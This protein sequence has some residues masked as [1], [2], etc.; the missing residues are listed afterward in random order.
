MP[1][2]YASV[3]SSHAE[4]EKHKRR[5]AEA[6]TQAAFGERLSSHFG[7]RRCAIPANTSEEMEVLNVFRFFQTGSPAPYYTT[8]HRTLGYYC[9]ALSSRLLEVLHVPFVP[10]K[11]KWWTIDD[12]RTHSQRSH[13]SCSACC[14]RR[15]AWACEDIHSAFEHA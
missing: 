3:G 7:R 5:Q 6:G 11:R 14:S 10:R 12:P 4:Q 8:L 2:L 15:L 1:I 9:N 13:T